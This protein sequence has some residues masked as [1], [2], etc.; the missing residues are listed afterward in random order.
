MATIVSGM[1][2]AEAIERVR[3][4]VAVALGMR[5]LFLG[6]LG[7]RLDRA[8][9]GGRALDLADQALIRQLKPLPVRRS[10]ATWAM[11]KEA[12]AGSER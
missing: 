4:H 5:K 8:V 1:S 12:F 11:P 7:D 10:S 3:S 9:K 6:G 2:D